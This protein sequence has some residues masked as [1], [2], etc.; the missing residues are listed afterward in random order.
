M[1]IEQQR[2]IAIASARARAAEADAAPVGDQPSMMDRAIASPI[3]RGIHDIV[4]GTLHGAA[5]I[6]S[7][8][9]AMSGMKPA[10][11]AVANIVNQPYEAALSRNRNTPG[12]AAAR[13]EADSVQKL[14]G[15]SGFQDQ[16]LAPVLPTLAGATGLAGG[17]DMS[18]AMADAQAQGQNAYATQHP[19]L[20]RGAGLL[21]GLLMAP[22]GAAE[23]AAAIASR[24]Q[25][26]AEHA[27]S[28]IEGLMQAQGETPASIAA[29]ANGKP[30]TFG[31][32]LGQPGVDQMAALARRPGQTAKILD[33]I[34][35]QR[36]AGRNG[37]MLNDFAASSGI[38]PRL[39]QGDINSYVEAGRATVKPMYDA[40]RA[41]E[42]G[43][44]N[45]DLAKLAE[46]K[47]VREAMKVAV[48]D[49]E[50]AGRDPMGLGFTAQDPATGK[51]IQQPRPTA[52]AWDLIKKAMNRVAEKDSFGHP[53]PDSV[54]PGNYNITQTGKELTGVLR[55]TIPG[56]SDALDASGDYLSLKKAFEDGKNHILDRNVTADQVQ[57]HYSDMTKPEQDAYNGGQAAALFNKSQ[58]NLLKP[59]VFR[60]PLIQDKLTLT[61]G[62]NNASKFIN[63]ME[64]EISMSQNEHLLKSATGSRTTP[65]A[66][67]NA[68]LDAAYQPSGMVTNLVNAGIDGAMSGSVGHGVMSFGKNAVRGMADR[69]A[70]RG[71][72]VPVRDQ[73][74]AV[75]S[76]PANSAAATLGRLPQPPLQLPQI[77]N[78]LPIGP[79][80]LQ[81]QPS[82][83]RR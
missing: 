59:T 45:A 16:M 69:W 31:E 7:M 72:P 79:L 37:R 55:K 56:Y 29:K 78:R 60:Q 61:L 39:A 32:A 57:K 2:A 70:T 58:S 35:E 21:G 28:Y 44:W 30:M 62:K 14:R 50:E 34:V 5:D 8:L 63:N 15:G 66:E 43:V 77:G 75:L 40:V 22:S 36:T 68:Q 81:A 4:G 9:P 67:A 25:T 71:M 46:R 54:S 23:K 47:S 13:S 51:F 65:L 19:W 52:E 42:G 64:Q 48:A 11:D 82:M 1:N 53:I 17:L 3:G 6:A 38:D 27:G 74:G 76:S 20:A 80:L 41:Q 49:L 24:A 73:V 18:N 33:P 26:P 12:Y 10:A 83:A